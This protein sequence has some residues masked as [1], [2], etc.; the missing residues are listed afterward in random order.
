[1]RDDHCGHIPGG[2]FFFTVVT[3]LANR[4]SRSAE[5]SCAFATGLPPYHGETSIADRRHCDP[6]GP[7]AQQAAA[8]PATQSAGAQ[9]AAAAA[10]P[11]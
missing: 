11:S 8:A 3:I 1:M 5:T 10:R 2:C 7:S 4:G 6:A 9:R